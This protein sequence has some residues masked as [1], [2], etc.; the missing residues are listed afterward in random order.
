M[1]KAILWCSK[2]R[3]VGPAA[4]EV[5]QF[6][7]VHKSPMFGAF[8]AIL[9]CQRCLGNLQQ[10]MGFFVQAYAIQMNSLGLA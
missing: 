2:I 1:I 10:G 8:R 7:M 5:D 6:L 3:L 9:S 4:E